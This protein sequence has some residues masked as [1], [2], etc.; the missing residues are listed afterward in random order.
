MK[1]SGPRDFF[2]GPVITDLISLIDKKKYSDV[3]F[4]LVSVL[5]RCIFLVRILHLN[6][7]ILLA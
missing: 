6:C 5:V 2:V 4:L 3:L 1:I 7:R